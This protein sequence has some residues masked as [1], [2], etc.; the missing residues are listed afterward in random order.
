MPSTRRRAALSGN[1]RNGVTAKTIRGDFG[2]VEIE[3]PRD[4]TGEFEPKIAGKRQTTVGNFTEIVISLYARGM[5]TR[6]IEEHVQ[7]IYGIEISPQFVCR[8]TEQ[9]HQQITDWQSRPSERI[10][11]GPQKLDTKKGFS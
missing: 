1:S 11:N 10:C 3:T 8:A 4:R 2:E 7:Q 5:S 6:E 9:L